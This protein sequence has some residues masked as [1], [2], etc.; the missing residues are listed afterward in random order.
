[1]HLVEDDPLNIAHN[2]APAV[3]HAAQDLG[4]HNEAGGVGVDGHVPGHEAHV[5]ELLL[6]VAEL[7]VAQRLDGRCVDDSLTCGRCH[8][9]PWE[10]RET[11]RHEAIS[12]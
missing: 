1:M 7:L 4:G 10:E 5:S 6:E 8:C 11:Y 2:V 9:M 12:L 3:Q